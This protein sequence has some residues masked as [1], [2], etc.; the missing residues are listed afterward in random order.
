MDRMTYYNEEYGCWSYYC[1][2]GDAAKRLAAYEDSGLTP[3]EVMELSKIVRCG[4]CEMYSEKGCSMSG[5]F[6]RRFN[7]DDFCSEGRRRKSEN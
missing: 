6:G 1:A 2:S 4:D 3:E 5:L 7:P